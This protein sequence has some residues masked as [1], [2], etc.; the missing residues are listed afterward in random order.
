MV[1]LSNEQ[2]SMSDVDAY[3]KKIQTGQPK[4]FPD[5]CDIHDIMIPDDAGDMGYPSGEDEVD[6]EEIVTKTG[7]ENVIGETF[8]LAPSRR[9]WRTL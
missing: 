5:D 1:A 9:S 6:E 4:G 2:L 7:F 8:H 3:V